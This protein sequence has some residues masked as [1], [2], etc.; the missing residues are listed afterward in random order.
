M[1]EKVDL[2]KYRLEQARES[3]QDAQYG[4][5]N[6]RLK[7]AVKKGI[8]NNRQLNMISLIRKEGL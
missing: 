2:C 5:M 7:L 6:N 3:L 4:L 8:N 1:K